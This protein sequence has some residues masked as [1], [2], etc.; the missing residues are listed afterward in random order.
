MHDTAVTEPH[1]ALATHYNNQDLDALV[2]LF[3]LDGTLVP[4]PGVALTGASLRDGLAG[5]L[6]LGGTMSVDVV[7]VVTVGD[8]AL[9]RT[10][11]SVDTPGSP[12]AVGGS[13]VEV[14]RRQADDTWR[15]LID[16]PFGPGPDT[17][18]AAP[19][20]TGTGTGTIAHQVDDH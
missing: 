5:L 10:T 8:L 18:A 14:V 1:R 4:E 15:F 7:D 17:Q 20:G 12:Q 13:G 19:T 2:Q 3:D 11:W 6:Q 9:T 16:S